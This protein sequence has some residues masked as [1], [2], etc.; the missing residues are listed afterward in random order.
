M[1]A[2]V[3]PRVALPGLTVGSDSGGKPKRELEVHQ[4][5]ITP[6]NAPVQPRSP[7]AISD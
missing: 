5:Q 7:Y 4:E 2:E 6:S 3:Q 1:L